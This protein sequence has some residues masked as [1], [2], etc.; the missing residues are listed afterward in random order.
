MNSVAL[1]KTDRAKKIGGFVWLAI[2]KLAHGIAIVLKKINWRKVGFVSWRLVVLIFGIL[3]AF[4][5]M[6][7]SLFAGLFT[8]YRDKIEN[9]ESQSVFDD[10]PYDSTNIS[11]HATFTRR[12]K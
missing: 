11:P 10:D 9:D 8:S 1:T 2:T 5:K 7:V 3:L 6:A 12:N 4:G